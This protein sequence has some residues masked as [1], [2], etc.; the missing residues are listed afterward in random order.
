VHQHR[1]RYGDRFAN[2]PERRRC[3][4]DLTGLSV[5][6]RKNVSGINREVA[7]TTDPS[8]LHRWLTR[9]ERDVSRL[10]ARRLAL[11][12]KD[13]TTRRTPQGTLP[14]DTP[15]LDHDGKL[16]DAGGWCW[17]HA[18]QRHLIA[19]DDRSIN[20]GCASAKH[21]PLAFRRFRK[22]ETCEVAQAQQTTQALTSAANATAQRCADQ[23]ATMVPRVAQ[24]I[25]QTTCRVLRG[26]T[27]PAPK[28][29]VSLF[30]P[31]TAILRKGK[32]GKPGESGR[33]LWLEEVGGGIITRSRL[34]AGHPDE[35]AQVVPSVDAHIERFG[36]PPEAER[37]D[38]SQLERRG[39]S[40]LPDAFCAEI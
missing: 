28:K 16:S 6:E 32:P 18:D 7:V 36:H 5:A 25:E 23:P 15:L 20:D 19:H 3:A 4:E 11:L 1:A 27:V 26:E 24:V 21:Y 17:H 8:C 39:V 29:V 34:L 9:V 12:Q 40:W 30:E 10:N 2:E 31:H 33:V 35:A 38:G 14:R 22:G 37:V 13:S